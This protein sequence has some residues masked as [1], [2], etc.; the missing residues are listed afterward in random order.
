ML[1]FDI[2]NWST[3]IRLLVKN[4]DIDPEKGLED[5]PHCT[6]LYG[7][8]ND[9]ELDSLIHLLPKQ[10]E[11]NC[12]TKHISL[13]ENENDVLKFEII[14]PELQKLHEAVKKF[15]NNYKYPDYKP[16][17]TIG[18]LKKGE[19]EK[20]ITELSQSLILKPLRFSFSYGGY[21]ERKEFVKF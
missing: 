18:Y 7:F 13:F 5:E 14:S 1:D 10:D 6:I 19:G 8:E 15:P 2:P 16:H 20:Y 12:Y 11:L 3:F 17:C 4:E 21:P 9:V